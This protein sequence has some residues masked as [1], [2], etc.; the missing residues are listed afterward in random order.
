MAYITESDVKKI[1]PESELI[2]L[3][4]D[5]GS[6]SV[7]AAN[8]AQCIAD[9]ESIIDSYLRPQ[10]TIPLANPGDLVKKIDIE[11]TIFHLHKRRDTVSES[12]RAYYDDNMAILKSIAKGE[13]AIDDADS[14]RATGGRVQTNKTSSSKVYT[15]T[16][17]DKF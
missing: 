13:I 14:Y 11:L 15:K 6:G 17:T 8:L 4:D 10:H 7:D 2:L 1:L 5:S 16:E 12:I 9:S 3:T